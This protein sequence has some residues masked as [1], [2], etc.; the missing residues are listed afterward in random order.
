MICF[1]FCLVV[2]ITEM[3]RPAPF[4]FGHPKVGTEFDIMGQHEKI[5]QQINDGIEGN[6]L[7][8][9]A[10]N[11]HK[12][13]DY[14]SGECYKYFYVVVHLKSGL[15]GFQIASFIEWFNS[16]GWPIHSQKRASEFAVEHS[17]TLFL[18]GARLARAE[19]EV[20][21]KAKL[22]RP[23]FTGRPGEDIHLKIENIPTLDRLKKE[24]DALI[25]MFTESLDSYI[26]SWQIHLTEGGMM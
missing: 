4:S 25:K 24:R 16:Q 26:E 13:K 3:A 11:W 23:F 17:N 9:L 22:L 1:I 14:F 19:D 12:M 20:E 10:P 21:V 8:C 5:R 6:T 7:K 2:Q 15:V 18:K